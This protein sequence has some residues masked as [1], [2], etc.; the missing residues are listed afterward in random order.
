MSKMERRATHL[1]RLSDLRKIGRVVSASLCGSLLAKSSFWVWHCVS[2]LLL[3]SVECDLS[4]VRVELHEFKLRL[5]VHLV[6][7]GCVVV[8]PVF[9]TH[10]PNNFSLFAFFCHGRIGPFNEMRP[11]IVA[12]CFG[13]I[14]GRC[15]IARV[16]SPSFALGLRRMNYF[17]RF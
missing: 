13:P 1:L 10:K 2:S 5:G 14:Q 7:R 3:L 16:G 15:L 4:Q 6:L 12:E 17:R 8:F 11:F 9:G